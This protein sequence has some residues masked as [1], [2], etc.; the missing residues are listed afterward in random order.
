MKIIAAL[1]LALFPGLSPAEPLT[2]ASIAEPIAGTERIE[3]FLLI[4]QSNMKGRGEVPAEQVANPR[5]VM[6]HVK[7]DQWYVARHPLHFAGDPVTLQGK[8]NAGV[9]PGLAFAKAVAA[10][11]PH[12][13]IALVPCA[14]GGTRLD[15]WVKGGRLYNNAVRR[16][17]LALSTKSSVPIVLRGALWLQGEADA[18]P[19]FQPTYQDR[20]LHMIDDLRGDLG[21]PDLPFIAATIGQF[22]RATANGSNLKPLINEA[23]LALPK[24]RP[25]AACVDARDLQGQIGDGVHYDTGSAN[26]IGTRMAAQFESMKRSQP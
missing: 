16:A 26:E 2:P 12:V 23:L 5:I 19:E 8:D 1:A 13:M 24:L 10:R 14:V 4:G 7:S 22:G 9:G 17:K 6:M 21:A 18:R 15:L 11:E 25:Y 20:L 3:L